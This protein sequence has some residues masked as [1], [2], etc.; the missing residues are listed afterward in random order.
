[1]A[2][3]D[4]DNSIKIC[5]LGPSFGTGN[6]GVDAL[7]ESSIKVIVNR[8]PEAEVTLLGSGWS[9]AEYCLRLFER[10]VHIKS[11]PIRFCKNIFQ[12]DHF[13][14]LFFYAML[15]KVFRGPRMRQALARRNPYLRVITEADMVVDITGGD[16]F[17]D[18]YGMRRFITGF[19]RKWLITA[20]RKTLVLLPQTYGPFDKRLTRILARRIIDYA[21]LVYSRDRKGLDDVEALLGA[22]KGAGK[23]K[24]VPDVG[25]LLDP[26]R[27]QSEE[28]EWL[29]KIKGPGTTLVGLNISGLLS[30]SSDG[31]DNIFNLKVDYT[32][33]IDSIVEY[34]MKQ[35]GT[36]ILLVPHVVSVRK[37]NAPGPKRVNKKGY[38]EQSDSVVC[39]ELYE[40]VTGKHP[41]RIFLVRGCYDR[42]ETKYIIGLCDFFIGSRMHSC[43]AALS[44]GIPAVGVAYSGKF[45]GVFESVGVEDCVADARHCAE[46]EILEKISSAYQERGHIRENLKDTVPC[47]QSEVLDMFKV[48]EL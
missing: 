18:I 32:A 48:L 42:N 23:V 24:F 46:D 29:E 15:I 16:S 4:K 33:L 5:L 2:T 28:V 7:V 43:I 26:R 10:D 47:V 36:T 31:G 45:H 1:M 14:V 30:C 6:L 39:A 38:R 9:D 22:G 20:F 13:M 40:R 11:M 21:T 17:S 34:L 19:L 27:P 41:G 44:Q 37:S 12:S 35:E 3:K 8:W 25:F